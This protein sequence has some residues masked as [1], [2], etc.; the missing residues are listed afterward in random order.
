MATATARAC[1]KT[2]LM[3]REKT[4]K[5]LSFTL[6][7]IITVVLMA[8]TVMEKLHGTAYAIENI[9]CADWMIALWGTGTL[10]AIVYL[11]QRKLH[12][13]PATLCLHIAFAVI[14][15]GALV[16]HTTGKQGQLHL[17]VGEYSN[18]YA[19]PDGE[20]EKLPFSISLHGFEVI[21]YA[22]TE[23]PMDYVSDIV[24]YD[25]KRTEGTI[26]MNNIF[27]YR[28]YRLYQAG[29][30]SD[31]KGTFLTVSYDPWGIGTTYTGYAILLIAML[32]FFTQPDS[33]FRTAL[34][35]GKSV[36]MVLLML[37]ATTTANAQQAAPAVPCSPYGLHR[38]AGTV[39]CL[40][41]GMSL[42]A[43][44]C[45]LCCHIAPRR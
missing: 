5:Y 39:S 40:S 34:R 4:F 35:K 26:S 20:T 9:Y 41:Q 10:S 14:L 21:R 16:T 2:T 44:G 36:A 29:Y 18:L 8:A 28:G 7:A 31:G 27:R 6:F 22:G 25:S 38:T 37:L 42:P 13:Q 43:G 17:R 15:A 23:A 11:L 12:R 19:L 32:L 33:R 30:D 45:C 1:Y 3:K 24:I